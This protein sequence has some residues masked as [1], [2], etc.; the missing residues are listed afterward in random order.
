LPLSLLVVPTPQP[1]QL[2]VAVQPVADQSEVIEETA[3][4]SSRVDSRRQAL[5]AKRLAEKSIPL[6]PIDRIHPIPRS[7]ILKQ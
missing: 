4:I 5:L 3:K 1:R 7:E 6:C 2:A